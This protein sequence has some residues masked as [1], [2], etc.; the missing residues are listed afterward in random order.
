M[1]DEEGELREGHSESS[2]DSE[3]SVGSSSEEES[4]LDLDL[5]VMG[6]AASAF[7]GPWLVNYVSGVAHKAV[8][9]K[10]GLGLACRPAA[11]SQQ[12]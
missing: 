12:L 1:S 8:K 2:N 6:H 9:Q 10:G 7:L 3:G 11:A 4:H 5:S